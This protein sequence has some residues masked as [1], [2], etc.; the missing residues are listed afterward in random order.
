MAGKNAV[1]EIPAKI[2]DAEFNELDKLSKIFTALGV[3]TSVLISSF[4]PTKKDG[5]PNF[6]TSNQE[7]F[8]VPLEA[9]ISYLS[10]K[11]DMILSDFNLANVYGKENLYKYQNEMTLTAMSR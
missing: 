9:V 5:G 6:N 7:I 11:G 4:D 2:S 8:D 1:I 3:E 10:N